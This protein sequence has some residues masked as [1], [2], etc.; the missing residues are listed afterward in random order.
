LR[1]T[2][3]AK[4]PSASALSRKDR[5]LAKDRKSDS[6]KK[7]YIKYEICEG[8]EKNAAKD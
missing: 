6:E 7:I 8:V 1:E 4:C 3:T 2:S 5:R